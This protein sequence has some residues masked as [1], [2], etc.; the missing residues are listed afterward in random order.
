MAYDPETSPLYFALGFVFFIMLIVSAVSDARTNHIP[1]RCSYSMMLISL[2]VLVYNRQYL[3]A[4]YYVFSVFS[5]GS[6]K[7]KLLLFTGTAVVFANLGN[8]AFPMVFSLAAA[9][10]LFSLRIIA[11]GDAQLLF[12]MLAFGYRDWTMSAAISAVSLTAG[13]VFIL[14]SGS[15]QV[16]KTRIL[17]AVSHL[18]AGTVENDSERIR[19]PFASLLPFSF[20]LFL[21]VSFSKF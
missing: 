13:T 7:L 11:G 16:I 19:I 3:L 2:I 17:T 9:D 15:F 12:A 21:F 4:A 20:L 1:K 18:K 6:K 14:R 8:A 10:L 5:T